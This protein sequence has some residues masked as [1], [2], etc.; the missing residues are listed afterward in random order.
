MLGGAANTVGEGASAVGGAIGDAS[1]KV[2]E[3]VSAAGD[4]VGDA[5]G[6]VKSGVVSA[7]ETVGGVAMKFTRRLFATKPP[8]LRRRVKEIYNMQIM[9]INALLEA[10]KNIKKALEAA[11]DILAKAGDAAS[12]VKSG[13]V[14]AGETVG[15]AASKFILA[16]SLD[17]TPAVSDLQIVQ[18]FSIAL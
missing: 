15:N 18:D 4:A 16:L 8:R 9:E 17:I 1:T 3:G 7:G 13:V 11:R 12:A 2:G 14:S 10:T 5:A 6:A